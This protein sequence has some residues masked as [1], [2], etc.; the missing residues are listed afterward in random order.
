MHVHKDP[1]GEYRV[2]TL[3]LRL[4]DRLIGWAISGAK[5]ELNE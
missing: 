5:S 4:E 1:D 2:D 3:G